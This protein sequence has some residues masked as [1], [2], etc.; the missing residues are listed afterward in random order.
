[1]VGN[2]TGNVYVFGHNYF[3]S[4]AL[5]PRDC[6]KNVTMN[7]IANSIVY[8]PNGTVC[9]ECVLEYIG[10][11]FTFIIKDRIVNSSYPLAKTVHGDV[12]DILVVPNTER[13]FKTSSATTVQCCERLILECDKNFD[14]M[15]ADVFLYY[16]KSFHWLFNNRLPSQHSTVL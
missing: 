14:T 5:G 10:L 16:S 9:F 12:V 6:E 13:V 3:F 1:M 11:P 8:V 4:E 15:K 7:N 2:T